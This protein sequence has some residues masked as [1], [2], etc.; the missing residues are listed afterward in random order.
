MQ[1][2]P[3]PDPSP[4]ADAA[5]Q[6]LIP[7]RPA[8]PSQGSLGRGSSN[9][10]WWHRVGYSGLVTLA[11]G[12]LAILASCAVLVFLW[13]GAGAARDRREPDLWKTVVSRG[14]APRVVTICSAAIRT[15]MVF[16]VGHVAAA[17]AALILE[18]SGA[19][20]VD[21][22]V[23]STERALKSSPM[24]ILPAASRRC[25][26]AGFS[27]LV[28][29]IIVAMGL[30]F[31]VFSTFISTILLSDF[32]SS[33]IV[34]PGTTNPIAFTI[35]QSTLV[36]LTGA[37]YWKSRPSANWRFAET[38]LSKTLAGWNDMGDTYCA[39]L[40]IE[41]AGLRESLELY[42]GLAVV[43][44]L[45]T[46]CRGPKVSG[47]ELKF[48]DS[49]QLSRGPYWAPRS[50][51]GGLHLFTNASVELNTII[52]LTN[53]TDTPVNFWCEL[54][55]FYPNASS[56]WPLSLCYDGWSI[57]RFKE[58]SDS[59]C[60]K[61][62][63]FS[64]V[65]LLNSSLAL[66]EI[67]FESADETDGDGIL[68]RIPS[69]L[70]NLTTKVEG[71]WTK[72]FNQ[73]GVEMFGITTCFVNS[74]TP[75]IYNV[76]MSGRSIPSEPVIDWRRM[77]GNGVMEHIGKQFE[78]G[79]EPRDFQKR[80]ILDLDIKD[81]SLYPKH[82]DSSWLA[83]KYVS[84]AGAFFILHSMAVITEEIPVGSSSS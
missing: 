77:V 32:R 62:Q 70:K 66:G 46:L 57:Y 29:F 3:K 64:M 33:H 54:Q 27:G 75:M 60:G 65:T 50:G 76:T 2:D 71:V 53:H 39:L 59:L 13:W 1:T 47:A 25:F 73:S 34:L 28:H 10:A 74:P 22:G 18:K 21:V 80:G 68:Y 20:L 36:D 14:W 61:S 63:S 83:D 24:N 19:S 8:S 52:I 56:A 81:S 38:K 45:R 30:I 49:Q 58:L 15:S 67:E 44:N 35:N 78:V 11:A 17:A 48:W 55:T 23:L 16:H 5:I 42:N 9:Q 37:S 82:A 31:L 4:D 79:V 72:F 41:R 84:P 6:P 7:S 26:K 40:P 12:A 51:G 43:L 69:S